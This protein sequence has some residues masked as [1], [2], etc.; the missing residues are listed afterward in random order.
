MNMGD[1]KRQLPF[2]RL[3][4]LWLAVALGASLPRRQGAYFHGVHL[5]PDVCWAL[6]FWESNWYCSLI[7]SSVRGRGASTFSP[8]LRR[9]AFSP[10]ESGAESV[11]QTV[12]DLNSLQEPHDASAIL[13]K[14][15]L[16]SP[17]A[18]AEREAELPMVFGKASPFA[19]SELEN[20]AGSFFSRCADCEA[21]ANG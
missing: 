8:F 5:G 10:L 14:A 7:A 21:N 12:K 13:G 4:F 15:S 11:W 6:G 1:L 19:S 18:E 3:H 16:L 2:R 9:G 17:E 20:S